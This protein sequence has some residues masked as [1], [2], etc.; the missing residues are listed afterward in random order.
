MSSIE[1]PEQPETK[2]MPPRYWWLKRI[3]A[4]A[5]V[6]LIVVVCGHWLWGVAA[7]RNLQKKIAQLRAAG[8]PVLPEDFEQPA[9]P[10]EENAAYFVRRAA[11]QLVFGTQAGQMAFD[12]I[13]YDP[14]LVDE[15]PAL[16]DQ[17]IA[18]NA[19]GLALIRQARLAPRCN[20]DA[21]PTAKDMNGSTGDYTWLRSCAKLVK[22]AAMVRHHRGD[23]KATVALLHD[24]LSIA[25]RTHQ[26]GCMISLLVGISINALNSTT[27]QY[28]APH[29]NVELSIKRPDSGV[30]ASRHSVE[31]LRKRLLDPQVDS[32]AWRHG[33][34]TDRAHML[35]S[36]RTICD[37]TIGISSWMWPAPPPALL[38]GVARILFAPRWRS[39]AGETLDELSAVAELGARANWPLAKA[40]LPPAQPGSTTF[41]RGRIETL[42]HPWREDLFH[43]VY[44][45]HIRSIAWKRMA[46]VALA[47]RLY[48]IDNG[49]R[50][51]SLREL[52][53]AYLVSIPEDP[54]AMDRRAIAY[55]PRADV[56]VLYSVGPNGVDEDGAEQ[57]DTDGRYDWSKGDQRFLLNREDIPR[58]R[59]NFE[60]AASKQAVEQN[61]F[62]E[63]QSGNSDERQ[64][65]GDE[66]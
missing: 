40:V 42:L 44:L 14:R 23:D 18:Q 26:R 15:F 20:W 36:T 29:L 62:V 9:V 27:I 21:A 60:P 61:P 22:A 43:N 39:Q 63:D 51:E 52:V 38:D 56:P 17:A 46:A 34:L 66:P 28:I 8:Q 2:P 24:A 33:I 1:A 55:R 4:T 45:Q 57:L 10:D 30:A 13:G 6:L 5:G 12:D 11:A 35:D 59:G 53:P 58:N 16:A 64:A 25:E 32:Q 19:A 3:L 41:L 37:G 7:E 50:P 31:H 54:Y 48:E 47:I 49:R 65:P